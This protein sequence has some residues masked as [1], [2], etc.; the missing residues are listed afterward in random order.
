MKKGRANK[1]LKKNSNSLENKTESLIN[2]VST[3]L[4]STDHLS[5]SEYSE[6]EC[7]IT[8]DNLSDEI[9]ASIEQVQ[10]FFEKSERAHGILKTPESLVSKTLFN[11]KALVQN[12][13]EATLK[14]RTQIC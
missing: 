12:I 5:D 2:E 10:E 1:H 6:D 8:V 4:E 11:L 3:S 14:K 7:Q 9:S 13:F